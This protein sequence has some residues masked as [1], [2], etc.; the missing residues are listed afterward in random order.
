MPNSWTHVLFCEQV[1][2]TAGFPKNI[3]NTYMKLG[4]QGPDP[5]FY[6]NFWPWA[7]GKA[8]DEVGMALHTRHCGDFLMSLISEAKQK[9]H[10][11]KAYVMGFVTHHVLD[12]NTHPYI[13]YHAGYE[14]SNH[15]KLETIIDTLMLEKYRQLRTWKTPVYKE[16]DIGP[17]LDQEIEQLLH[18]TMEQHY[19]GLNS[20]IT[21]VL[22]QKAYKDMRLALKVLFDPYGWKNSL[23]GSVVSSYSHRP[24]EADTDYLN[25]DG[26][27][28]HHPATNEP[29]SESFIDLYENALAEGEQILTAV[30]NYWQDRSGAEE[31]LRGLIGDVSYDNGTA[32][33]LELENKYSDPIV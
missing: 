27:M 17:G 30:E 22:L 2:D 4:A 21:H 13:H 20:I 19:P 33:A 18:E 26:K 7:D 29:R 25:L 15:Q 10:R 3:V 5:F 6:Y 1:A 12:R 28:W 24:V 31:E 23:L 8:G 11:M 32:I 16:I 9:D 14:G